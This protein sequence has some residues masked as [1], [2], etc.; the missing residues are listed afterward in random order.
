MLDMSPFNYPICPICSILQ[1]R[2]TEKAARGPVGTCTSQQLLCGA[3]ETAVGRKTSSPPEI[4]ASEDGRILRRERFQ[5]FCIVLSQPQPDL[6]K[7][8]P[9]QNIFLYGTSHTPRHGGTM[10]KETA[11][12]DNYNAG[13]TRERDKLGHVPIHLVSAILSLDICR[14]HVTILSVWVF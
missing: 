8:L 12:G 4:G 7:G 14:W 6:G 9:R 2:G 5:P 10:K 1:M 11:A 13:G 3:S